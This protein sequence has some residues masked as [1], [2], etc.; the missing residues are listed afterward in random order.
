MTATFTIQGTDV[1]LPMHIPTAGGA[2]GLFAADADAVQAEL[3]DGLSAVRLPGGRGVVAVMMVDYVDNPLGDYD[4]GVVAYAAH[5]SG[6]GGPVTTLRQLLRGRYGA[7][8]AH[9]PVSQA[10]TREA[11]ET[12][13]GYP[14]TVDDLDLAHGAHPATMRWARDGQDILTLSVARGGRVPGLPVP[15]TTYTSMGG[16]VHATRLTARP[17]RVGLRLRGAR[18]E[19]GPHPVGVTLAGMGVRPV[20]LASAWLGEV[21]MDFAPARPLDRGTDT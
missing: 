20:A 12:I 16:V 4:E 18:L 5:P 11:G 17:R 6:S 21:A 3:P 14:K 2:L 10:F 1:A 19:L 15:A 7:W 8:I 9:M 13:W